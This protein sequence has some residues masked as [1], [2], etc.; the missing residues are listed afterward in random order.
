MEE[1]NL[2][3]AFVALLTSTLIFHHLNELPI[4]ILGWLKTAVMYRLL[5]YF[6]Y[7]P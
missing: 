1:S 7:L 3:D 4:T 5:D 2:A 6:N